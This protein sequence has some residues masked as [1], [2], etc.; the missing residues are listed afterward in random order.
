MR[1]RE[2]WHK[3]SRITLCS[4]SQ[5]LNSDT[6][7]RFSLSLSLPPPLSLSLPLSL[8]FSSV[9]LSSPISWYFVN[10]IMIFWHMSWNVISV[11]WICLCSGVKGVSAFTGLVN[12]INIL[13]TVLTLI[14]WVHVIIWGGL[15]ASFH[16]INMP[17]YTASM[18]PWPGGSGVHLE[19]SRPGFT[20]RF[21]HGFFCSSLSHTSDLQNW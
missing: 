21:G 6:C 16:A 2:V 5:R 7:Q 1:W 8:V 9:S 13:N 18:P 4:V 10:K 19:S 17:E 12:N 11:Q 14:M 3:Q 15:C 20:S